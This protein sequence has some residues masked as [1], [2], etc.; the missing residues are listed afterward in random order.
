M[1][2]LSFFSHAAL[3]TRYAALVSLSLLMMLSGCDPALNWREVRSADAGYTVL[4]P[5]KPSTAE[6]SVDLNGLQVTMRMTAAETEDMNFAVASAVIADDAQR[7]TALQAM[8]TAMTRNIQG[9]I[10]AQKTVMLKPGVSATEIRVTGKAARSGKPVVM[11]A[12]FLAHGSRVYQ[13]I[14][15]GPPE[16]LDAEAAETF[17]N[18]FTLD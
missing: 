2:V 3:G 18:S 10:T 13:L 14:A 9:Q 6:R 4:L 15:L 17:M 7:A 11:F 1:H 16:K 12:R 5:A 8:Q